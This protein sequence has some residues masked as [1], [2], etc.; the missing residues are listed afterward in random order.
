MTVKKIIK[1]TLLSFILLSLLS[2]SNNLPIIADSDSSVCSTYPELYKEMTEDVKE[3]NTKAEYQTTFNPKNIS[4]DKIKEEVKEKDY[5]LSHCLYSC[6]W[7]YE[8][9]PGSNSL[10]SVKIEYKYYMTEEQR[11]DVISVC[12]KTA[13]KLEGK[14]DYEKIKAVHDHIILNCEYDLF[15]N[16]PYNCLY[17]G[18]ACCNGYALAFQMMMD[19]CNIECRYVA[20]NS[21]AWNAVYLDNAW[22]NID[23]TWDDGEGSEVLYTYFLKSNADFPEHPGADATA[24]FSYECNPEG[25][26]QPSKFSFIFPFAF[27]LKKYWW[28]LLLIV[29]AVIRVII[30]MGEKKEENPMKEEVDG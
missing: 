7:T 28:L 17:E 18:K 30:M 23:V 11:E 29:M 24:L 12:E 21:H 1:L 13:G 5:I 22:Y 27:F 3:W 9:I 19:A 10:Y 25:E 6:A 2:C 26:G 15:T 16:G 4:L 14:S 20:N 8:Q